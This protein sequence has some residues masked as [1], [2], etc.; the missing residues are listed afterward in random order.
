M[1]ASS[2]RRRCLIVEQRHLA[3]ARHRQARVGDALHDREQRHHR[4]EAPE[5]V[6]AEIPREDHRSG[7]REQIR[8]DEAG[9]ALHAAAD[10]APADIRV[11][12][13]VGRLPLGGDG[14][15]GA[16]A[17]R[18]RL[19]VG[20]RGRH[21]RSVAVALPVP[22]GPPHD[23]ADRPRDRLA[24]DPARPPMPSSACRWRSPTTTRAL[25]WID[26][27]I[28][29]AQPRVRLRRR[30]AHRRRLRRGRR[31]ARRGAGRRASPCPTASRSSG[32]CARSATELADRVYG[33][34]ADGART[35]SA[36]RETGTRM[37]LYGGRNQGALVQLALQ[38]APPLPRPADRRRLLA[39]VPPAR[40]PRRSDA[41]VDEIN[42]SRRRRR[43]GRHRRAQAGE[44]DG[45]RCAT[46]LD[47]PG[48]RRRRRR[49][50]LP[51]RA[52]ARRRR[53]GCRRSGLEWAFRLAQEPRRLWRRYAA[54]QP[55]LRRRLRAAVRARS[56]RAAPPHAASLHR[57]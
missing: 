42:R 36:R 16:P 40:P 4:A 8:R 45:A 52:R 43:L 56:R 17:G 10:H 57:A 26:A 6:D 24:P 18:L 39:A 48:A 29:R 27:A 3:R 49:V 23:P 20:T 25:D 15:D 46:R 31:A 41:V 47:A 54:L 5:V 30:D 14:V 19:A 32:R 53:R 33:P 37:F 38:P 35:A 34:D 12:Q 11:A 13:N 50:R 22:S 2:S 9:H 44:V 28:A 55:A 51:R 21:R 7:K 1:C